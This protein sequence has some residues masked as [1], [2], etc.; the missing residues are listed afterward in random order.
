LRS[1][2][3]E[4]EASAQKEQP[5]TFVYVASAAGEIEVVELD[6]RAGDLT[7]RGKVTV[8]APV[9]SLAG[10]TLGNLLL[11]TTDRG[12]GVISLAVD[13]K[14]GVL[15]S[16]SR[17]AV[18]G[19]APM[20]AVVD[21]SGRYVVV[22]NYGSG[23]VSIVPIRPDGKLAESDTFAAGQGATAVGFHPSNEVAFVVNERA[24]SISQYSFNPGTGA[25]T[26]KP[27]RPLG[28]PGGAHPRQIRCHPNGRFVYVLNETDQTVSAYTFDDRMGT[29][30]HLAF[31]VVS[32]T[33][34]GSPPSK[35]RGGSMRFGRKGKYLYVTNRGH[36][37]IAV[38]E[39]GDETGDLSLR[40]QVASGGQDP[41]ELSMD[42]S[43]V[44]L[45]VANRESRNLAM[46]R[47]ADNGELSA[48]GAFTLSLAPIA[49]HTLRPPLQEPEPDIST[50]GLFP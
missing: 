9:L 6:T 16:L 17:A 19:T 23:N 41:I 38:F 7:R 27:G 18:G 37:T 46:F 10:A 45:V 28:L 15:K 42:P 24:G 32:T 13:P 5:H 8:G 48:G 30:T 36:D 34:E 1:R 44:F 33:P 31:Q 47:I 40:A 4:P 29:L 35:R 22:A 26:P 43:G 11:A 39:V 14:T 21:G 3:P 12:A 25:L 50:R 20:G 2:P 49:L